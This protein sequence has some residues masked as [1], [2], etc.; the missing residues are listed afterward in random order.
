[1]G[2]PKQAGAM[3]RDNYLKLDRD[4]KNLLG[5]AGGVPSAVF[6]MMNIHFWIPLLHYFKTKKLV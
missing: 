3:L 6:L 5:M 4:P 2:G 1:L